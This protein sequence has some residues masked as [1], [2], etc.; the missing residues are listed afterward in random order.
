VDTAE[1]GSVG[2]ALV[3]DL[4]RQGVRGT[5]LTKNLGDRFI[6][7]GAVE[8][9]YRAYGLDGESLCNLVLEV[10]THEK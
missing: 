7:H 1:A 6:P 5:F 8:T 3:T 10:R 2:Q 9:L 4:A